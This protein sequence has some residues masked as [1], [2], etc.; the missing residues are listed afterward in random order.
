M[1]VTFFLA[2]VLAL[3]I[4]FTPQLCEAQGHHSH[5]NF[6]ITFYTPGLVIG[7][8]E[9]HH[10]RSSWSANI[11]MPPPVMY[12]P[13]QMYAPLYA[14]MPVYRAPQLVC[15]RPY[16]VMTQYGQQWQKQCWVQ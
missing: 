4:T 1:R 7:Y 13:N 6:G 3:G 15:G 14:P 5:N 10:G 8:G 12:A 16:L 2:F 11:M 9:N